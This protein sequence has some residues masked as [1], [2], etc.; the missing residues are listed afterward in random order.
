VSFRHA[1]E[2]LRSGSYPAASPA[3]IKRAAAPALPLLADPEASDAELM[4]QVVRF[5]H[6]TLKESPE[7]LTYL[8]SRG[9]RSAEMIERFQL[10]FSNRT[11][12]YRVPFKKHESVSSATEFDDLGAEPDQ[13]F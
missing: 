3:R 2:M 8:E 1:F 4:R 6:Q 7:A 12:G 10:G 5:Y 11:L 13:F 9:L